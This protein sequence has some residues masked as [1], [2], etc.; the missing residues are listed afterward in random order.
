MKGVEFADQNCVFGKPN[1][2]TDEEC[3]SLPAKRTKNGDFN[4]VESVWELTDEE[5]QI[6]TKS[7][8]I[9]LGILGNGIPPLYMIAEPNLTTNPV[10]NGN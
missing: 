4:A 8:R 7:K 6:I 2:M 1:T 3:Y 9:R 10:T 5:M